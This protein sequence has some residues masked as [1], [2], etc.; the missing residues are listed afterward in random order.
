MGQ[1]LDCFRNGVEFTQ[2]QRPGE[3]I[4]DSYEKFNAGFL[5]VCGSLEGN[6]EAI[7][8]CMPVRFVKRCTVL[9]HST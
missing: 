5:G 7:L 8:T 2:S 3:V 9:T 1:I 6:T 4:P